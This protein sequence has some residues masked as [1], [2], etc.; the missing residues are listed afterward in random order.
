MQSCVCDV[1]PTRR[2]FASKNSKPVLRIDPC[3]AGHAVREIKRMLQIY[4]LSRGLKELAPQAF[5]ERR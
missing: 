5:A 2:A 4:V 1:N 3:Q